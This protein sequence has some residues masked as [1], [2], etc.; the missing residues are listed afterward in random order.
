MLLL[1]AVACSAADVGI[2]DNTRVNNSSFNIE[3]GSYFTV[4]KSDWEANGAVWHQTGTL[5]P[6]FLSTVSV[7]MTGFVN[8]S[9]ATP[10]E[11]AA[12]VN[13]VKGGGTL[14]AIG[15]CS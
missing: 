9:G 12:L 3:T 1:L 2:F 13:W 15:E 4:L 14:V 10:D 6:A 8:A 5:T 7:F 11:Q